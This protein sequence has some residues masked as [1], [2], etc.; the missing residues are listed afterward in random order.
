MN[1][2]ID[3]TK[4]SDIRNGLEC[5]IL[6]EDGNKSIGIIDHIR[7]KNDDDNGLY[8]ILENGDSGNIIQI[9]NSIHAAKKRILSESHTSENKLNYYEPVMQEEQ[10]PHTVQAF[11]NSEGGYL[12]IGVRD[13]A[14]TE[15]G[16]F[17]G[18]SNEKK[19]LEEE[20]IKDKELESGEE[21]AWGK[22]EDLYVTAIE[23]KL[24]TI[25]ACEKYLGDLIRYEMKL[26]NE[27][28]I[29]EINIKSCQSPV[30]YKH[31]NKNN[32]NKQ[33][34][35]YFKNERVTS[36]EFDDFYYRNGSSKLPIKTFE[37]FYKHMKN[38]FM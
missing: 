31:L 36:R 29:L 5:E 13:D 11:L 16:K 9:L 8:V 7:S 24:S 33:F 38:K 25:L 30:F 18:L 26:I 14:K 15:S 3:I 37:E 34:D 20:L 2:F 23:K 32:N 35:I 21:L 10:I 22:F 17:V 12:Y 1:N 27:V 19:I 6:L 4:I 28:Y